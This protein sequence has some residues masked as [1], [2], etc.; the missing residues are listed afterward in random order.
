[1]Q[2]RLAFI[3]VGHQFPVLKSTSVVT[4]PENQLSVKR[5]ICFLQRDIRP[6]VL[7]GFLCPCALFITVSRYER[8]KYSLVSQY[9]LGRSPLQFCVNLGIIGQ[10]LQKHTIS[11]GRAEVFWC[12]VDHHLNRLPLPVYKHAPLLQLFLSHNCQDTLCLFPSTLSFLCHC[13]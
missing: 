11:V 2:Q 12:W 1:M 13:T 3:C 4:F 10:V 5:R 8:R 7:C 9:Y 6:K